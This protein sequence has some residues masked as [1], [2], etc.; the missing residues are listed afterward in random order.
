MYKFVLTKWHNRGL[1]LYNLMS[2][3]EFFFCL[4]QLFGKYKAVSRNQLLWKERNYAFDFSK[5]KANNGI[6]KYKRY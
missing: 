6:T 2:I 5:K 1:S 3:L 4:V